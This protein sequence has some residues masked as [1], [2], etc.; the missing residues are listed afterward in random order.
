MIDF[1]RLSTEDFGRYREL[2][3]QHSEETMDA[4]LHPNLELYRALERKGALYL[5]GAEEGGRPVGYFSAFVF[6]DPHHGFVHAIDDFYFLA[7]EYRNFRNASAMIRHAERD[8][9]AKGCIFAVL[10]S[11][12]RRDIGP[13]LRRLG[14]VPLET[15]YI[16]RLDR[17]ASSVRLPDTEDLMNHVLN[18]PGE[19]P[20]VS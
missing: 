5:L 16:R 11:P 20:W 3:E 6:R 10:R 15:S 17:R 2:M 13:F 7:P 14:Y 9:E 1:V 8:L 12:R 19:T 18:D 4:P